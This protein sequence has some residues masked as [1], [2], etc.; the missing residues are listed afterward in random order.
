MRYLDPSVFGRWPCVD[1]SRRLKLFGSEFVVR[2]SAPFECGMITMQTRID[3]IGAAIKRN[4]LTKMQQLEDMEAA[5]AMAKEMEEN[6]RRERRLANRLQS[7]WSSPLEFDLNIPWIRNRQSMQEQAVSARKG[8]N[9]KIIYRL[10]TFVFIQRQNTNEQDNVCRICL[11][12]YNDGDELRI[13]PCFHFYHKQCVD[14]W[15]TRMS[16]KCPICKTSILK[17]KRRRRL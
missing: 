7:E 6:E 8:V 10:P 9:A 2:R 5:Q 16:S 15:L 14:A 3:Y 4:E 17:K 13:L 12:P 11:E 1:Y